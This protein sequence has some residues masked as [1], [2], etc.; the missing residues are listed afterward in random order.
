MMTMTPDQIQEAVRILLG[1]RRDHRTIEA[2]PEA[3]RPRTVEEG[4]AIQD[5]LVRASGARVSGWKLGSTTPYWQKRA[6]LTEPMA[7]RLLETMLHRGSATFAGAHFHLRMVECEYAFEL[8][9]DLPPRAEPYRREEVED[10]VAAVY[11]AIEVA[12][13]RYAKGLIV[14]TPS[15]IADNVLTGAYLVGPE[16]ARWRDVDLTNAPVR[17]FVD[18]KQ[19]NEGKGENTGGHP[20]LP[21]VWLANDRRRRGDGLA[22]GMLISTGSTTGAYRSPLNADITAEFSDFGTMQLTFTA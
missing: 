11:G 5:A 8:G 13:S 12:D 17:V 1:A 18:G 4:Y 20:I 2:L 6:G 9:R 21:L 3:C 10:A 7:G 15:L 16:I 22:A 14:E 19:I